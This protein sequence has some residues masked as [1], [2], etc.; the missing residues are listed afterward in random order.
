MEGWEGKHGTYHWYS[1]DRQKKMALT[2]ENGRKN[3]NGIELN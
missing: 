2:N 1:L 3:G